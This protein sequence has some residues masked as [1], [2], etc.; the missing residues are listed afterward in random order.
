VAVVS[1]ILVLILAVVFSVEWYWL[2]T[3][4]R[5]AGKAALVQ[6][7]KLEQLERDASDGFDSADQQA[8]ASVV[9]AE[10]KAWTLRDRRTAEML[11]LYRW[12]LETGH[13]Y[14]IRESQLRL[15]ATQ[16]RRSWFSNPEL[17]RNLRDSQEQVFS[18]MRSFL[19]KELD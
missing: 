10:Q 4:E 11:E 17:E 8:K 1:G 2:T 5:I 14:R 13:E 15:I 9:V 12:E 7:E 19:H 16:R 6:I 3:A 18:S